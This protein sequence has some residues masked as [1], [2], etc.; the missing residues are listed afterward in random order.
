[1][2]M[3]YHINPEWMERPVKIWLI[4]VGGNGSETLDI[5]A[6]MHLA[7]QGAGHRHGFQ[8]TVWDGDTV[9]TSNIVKQR[10]WPC[11]IGQNKAALSVQRLNTHLNVDWE[12][13]PVHLNMKTLNGHRQPDLLITCTDSA[14]FRVKV[15]S[16]FSARDYNQEILW[17]DMGNGESTGQVVLGHLNEGDRHSIILPHVYDLYPELKNVKDNDA[18]SCSAAEALNAQT[19]GINKTVAVAAGNLLWALF[20]QASI[21]YHGVYLNSRDNIT[22]P[23]YIDTQVWASMNYVREAA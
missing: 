23:L 11:D 16:K 12:G 1:M 3:K 14:S 19:F 18:P 17:L 8:L 9:S 7:V 21:D 4:G 15:A 2:K 6:R 10:F 13:I 22:R 5:L 20:T